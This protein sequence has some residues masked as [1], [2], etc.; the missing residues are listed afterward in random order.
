VFFYYSL[1]TQNLINNGSFS[2]RIISPSDTNAYYILN[3]NKQILKNWYIPKY[4]VFDSND[5]SFIE[6][7]SSNDKNYAVKYK[8]NTLADQL[9]ENNL[10]FLYFKISSFYSVPILQQKISTQ[11]N[12][13]Y[14][15]L[16]FK[17]KKEFDAGQKIGFCF[18][19]TDLKENFIKGRFKFAADIS[20]VYLKDT[21]SPN[22]KNLPWKSVKYKIFL[23]GNEKY[24]SVGYLNAKI[25]SRNN[26]LCR[27]YIDDIELIDFYT[28]SLNQIKKTVVDS[29][30]ILFQKFPLNKEIINDSCFI[31]L[32]YNGDITQPVIPNFTYKYLD[33]VI[34]FMNSDK[35]IKLKIIEYE[36]TNNPYMKPKFYTFFLNYLTLYG[37]NKDKISVEKGRCY[38]PKGIYCGNKSH[39]LKMGLEFY[40]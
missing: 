20:Q 7:F 38:D 6:Y 37:I 39:I 34:S 2:D 24:F 27:Y 35:N 15:I 32:N 19:P 22:D 14:Y 8:R 31:F 3:S 28:D 26:L 36:Q 18:S 5:I 12:K 13:G 1:K 33:K 16:K 9:F 17:Y 21:L 29:T 30:S 10:G 23:T 4:L 25:K 40:L 11:I